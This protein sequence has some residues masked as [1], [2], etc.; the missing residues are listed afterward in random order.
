M[1]SD[2]PETLRRRSGDA[3]PPKHAYTVLVV[4][5]DADS[6]GPNVFN[7]VIGSFAN[8]NVPKLQIIVLAV[9]CNVDPSLRQLSHSSQ[10]VV[11]KFF[12]SVPE[13]HILNDFISNVCVFLIERTSCNKYF[14]IRDWARFPTAH[15]CLRWL[16]AL[17]APTQSL[18]S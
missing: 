3:E 14:S 10:K 4:L 15:L 18:S 2:I 16:T 11:R 17:A 6:C 5:D 9:L 12:F 7:D 1:F 13:H 8:H